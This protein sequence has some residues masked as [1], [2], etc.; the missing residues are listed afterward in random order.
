MRRFAIAGVICAAFLFVTMLPALAQDEHQDNHNNDARQE[1]RHDQGQ[2]QQD[3]QQQDRQ[4]QDRQ[5]QNRQD[6]NGQYRPDENRRYR[7]DQ[8]Q[9]YRQNETR[10]EQGRHEQGARA[11]HDNGRRIDEAHY[12]EHFGRDH[13]FAVHHVD[14]MDGRDRFYYSGYQ[15]ELAEP[16]PSEWSYDDNCYIEDDGGQY[17]LYDLNHPGMRIMVI[18]L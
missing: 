16:W 5:N 18:V 6:Q 11:E 14:R 10:P 15:F 17:Y 13:R 7:E 1:E 12:R 2:A 3:R 4:M 9:Q 8:N